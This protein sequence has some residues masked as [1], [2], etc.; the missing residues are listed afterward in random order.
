MV[1]ERERETSV[2]GDP[3]RTVCPLPLGALL[4]RL[5]AVLTTVQYN[6]VGER[7]EIGGRLHIA[8]NSGKCQCKNAAA[9]E[10]FV[11]QTQA[12]PLSAFVLVVVM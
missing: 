7:K 12:A 1:L 8:P 6:E 3:P 2:S 11:T 4:T 5:S 10:K 9:E